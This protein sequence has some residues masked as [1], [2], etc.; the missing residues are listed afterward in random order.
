MKT[1]RYW[2]SNLAYLF[3]KLNASQ[4]GAVDNWGHDLSLVAAADLSTHQYKFVKLNSSGQVAIVAA[5][6]D[7]PIGVL[8]N[9]PT[10]G[11]IATVRVEGVSK[12]VAGGTITAGGIT[13]RI[14]SADGTATAAQVLGTGPTDIILGQVLKSAAS[15]DVV[16]ATVQ[17]LVPNPNP[18]S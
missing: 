15:G 8:Q 2:L 6:T 17:C 1:I 13:G 4:V 14:R 5:V 9:K 12:V 10:S 7:V 3:R 11:K 16:Q 18:V